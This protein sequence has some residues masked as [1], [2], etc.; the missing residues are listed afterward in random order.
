MKKI[1]I[2]LSLLALL[3]LSCK[4]GDS[5]FRQ[6]FDSAMN[7]KQGD[8][9][10]AA[11]EELDSRYPDRLPLKINLAALHLSS[12][13]LEKALPYFNEGLPLAEKS[14][15]RDEKYMFY[16]NY[17]EYK[18]KEGNYEE[19]G[20]F[21]RKAL[22]N[23]DDDTLGVT[24]TL[25]RSLTALEKYSDAY[26]LFKEMWKTKGILFTEEDIITFISIMGIA[27]PDNE[28][29]VIMITLMDELKVKNPSIKGI[30]LK[31]AEILEQ[32]GAPLSALVSVFS[33]IEAARYNRTIDDEGTL[34]TLS[35][36]SERFRFPEQGES[37][38]MGLKL[39]EGYASF[40]DE[41]WEIADSV[42]TQ[43]ELEIP[44]TFYFYL[45]LASRI[46]TGTGTKEDFSN[47]A[48]LGRN[49]SDMQGFY[50]NYWKGLKKSGVDYN[51]ENAV[52]LLKG[53]ILAF[54]FSKFAAETRLELGKF[55]GIRNGYYILLKE[56]VEYLYK[57]AISGTPVD[58]L[59]PVARLL[60]ME[61]N[62]FVDDAMSVL[63]DAFKDENISAWF[64]ERSKISG[65]P[66]FIS[67]VNS[68]LS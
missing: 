35:A 46:E 67:R 60:E 42:F 27:P 36:L 52:P 4:S 8:E 29:L 23:T 22:E 44:V 7:E 68:I 48:T 59:E 47:Y 54:P 43:I 37:G 50:Y 62:V 63:K 28:N 53:C 5:E 51:K 39:I 34:K 56:E 13:D 2:L 58:V 57:R 6:E 18:F 31:Q 45:K 25:A 24:L 19:S 21:S 20:K 41:K 11:L 32:A 3:L 26:A 16:T 40:I 38:K 30:G 49:Y 17:A 66:L 65:N 33:E 1:I 55:Y 64:V 10:V 14:K 61:D 12:G 15:S 9:L